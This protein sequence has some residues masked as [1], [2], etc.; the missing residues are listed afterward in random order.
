VNVGI[1]E[2]SIDSVINVLAYYS[3]CPNSIPTV[4]T[5]LKIN[6]KDDQSASM[7]TEILKT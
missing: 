7:M 5:K 2:V 6:K 3:E 4:A 1:L